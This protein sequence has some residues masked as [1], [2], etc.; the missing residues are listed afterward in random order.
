MSQYL[1]P[2]TNPEDSQ[3]EKLQSKTPESLRANLKASLMGESPRRREMMVFGKESLSN[4]SF[5]DFTRLAVQP[6]IINP[7]QQVQQIISFNL[8]P[9]ELDAAAQQARLSAQA[10]V[11]GNELATTNYHFPE[12]SNPLTRIA[13]MI[14]FVLMI[15][16]FLPMTI[17][18]VA[19]AT[20][21]PTAT[22]VK[23][24]EATGTPEPTEQTVA[25]ALPTITPILR[26]TM[27]STPVATVEA[28]PTPETVKYA[29][30]KSDNTNIRPDAS[31][32]HD[33]IYTASAG[34]KLELT[35]KKQTVAGYTWYEVYVVKDPTNPQTGKGWVRSDLITM[36]TETRAPVST[37]VGGSVQQE[38][39]LPTVTPT[40]GATEA[41]TGTTTAPI[42]ET[43]QTTR[44]A[45]ITTEVVTPEI[46][47]ANETLRTTA[48]EFFGNALTLSIDDSLEVFSYPVAKS[49]SFVVGK[50]V[51]GKWQHLQETQIVTSEEIETYP[52]VIEKQ[53]NGQRVI[54]QNELGIEVIV[55]EWSGDN[56]IKPTKTAYELTSIAEELE[57]N[58]KK[59]A[60]TEAEAKKYL[61]PTPYE[62]NASVIPEIVEGEKQKRRSLVMRGIVNQGYQVMHVPIYTTNQENVQNQSNWKLRLV[63]LP[64][65]FVDA[66]GEWHTDNLIVSSVQ[67]LVKDDKIYWATLLGET[68][69]AD[70]VMQATLKYNFQEN[71]IWS[72]S[73]PPR[74]LAPDSVKDGDPVA[75]HMYDI[76][77]EDSNQFRQDVAYVV[78][79]VEGL[80]FSEN[81]VPSQDQIDFSGVL[82]LKSLYPGATLPF[83]AMLTDKKITELIVNGSES[84][85]LQLYGN[86]SVV[87]VIE[88]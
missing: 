33:P 81:D 36:V 48:Y 21:T 54:V 55:A 67:P 46:F 40:V 60:R 26:P 1:H 73:V 4:F 56:W 8:K 11:A 49:E 42:T 74:P 18:A 24:N 58:T 6:G 45:P 53:M 70:L 22:A 68:T 30:I 39:T 80:D 76:T 79:I 2:E 82:L 65:S 66:R 13:A 52:N 23:T 5:E 12:L 88:R 78:G 86:T 75:I 17:E 84:A 51:E 62:F 14:L 61:Y 3:L 20:L 29:V 47:P 15:S 35:G 7:E 34:E 83:E 59:I 69:P 32:S 87:H 85:S 63:V 43:V 28:T 77:N 10:F 37:G 41:I 31:T 25:Q 50:F 38:V 44:T 64:I 57:L 9:E 19:A 72:H 71:E 27:T 16:G